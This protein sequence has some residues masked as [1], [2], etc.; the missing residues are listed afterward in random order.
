MDVTNE[1]GFQAVIEQMGPL[2]ILV[3]NAGA[4]VSLP[5]HKQ[6]MADF[7]AMIA[8]NLASAFASML[9][10]LPGMAARGWGRVINISST[11]G[12][13]GYAYSA[14]Y[15]AAKHGLIGLTRSLAVEY[16]KTG[17]TINAVCPGW[18]DTDM[19]ADA[20]ALLTKQTNRT[21]EQ[22]LVALMRDNPQ[23]RLISPDEVANMVAY[24]C[25]TGAAAMNGQSV[26]VAGGEVM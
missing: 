21:P 5:F 22:A 3:N 25:G 14:P 19:V 8:V 7:N 1:A 12:L 6:T 10:V 23:G 2:D 24:L 20:V 17:V 16:A 11:A 9:A 26:I 13:K 15:C 18:T 4:S